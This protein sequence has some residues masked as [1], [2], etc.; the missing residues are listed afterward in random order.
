MPGTREG[1]REREREK[2]RE[3]GERGREK[4]RERD[5]EEKEDRG[6]EIKREGK[7][8]GGEGRGGERES[9]VQTREKAPV[10]IRNGGRVRRRVIGEDGPWGWQWPV[11][12]P[13][14]A[15]IP[16]CVGINA[17]SA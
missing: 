10:Q 3:G 1:E 2:E 15:H 17:T 16:H 8:R 12:G 4:K 6:R 7:E 5:E 9:S 13:K 11:W 14:T